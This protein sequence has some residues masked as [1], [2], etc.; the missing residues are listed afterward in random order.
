MVGGPPSVNALSIHRATLS[1]K[2][3]PSPLR[4]TTGTIRTNSSADSIVNTNS[5]LLL[6]TPDWPHI[7]LSPIRVWKSPTLASH[8]IIGGTNGMPE[9]V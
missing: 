4:P 1:C 7:P 2:R 3:P 9:A 5:T 6:P 8:Q